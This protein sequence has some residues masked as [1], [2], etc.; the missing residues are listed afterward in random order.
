MESSDDFFVWE[1]VSLTLK[2]NRMC[3]HQSN[4]KE[5]SVLEEQ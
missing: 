3:T 2:V 1:I 5:V 4:G